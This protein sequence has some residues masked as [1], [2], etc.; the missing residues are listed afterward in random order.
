MFGFLRYKIGNGGFT[1]LEMVVVIAIIGILAAV[2]IGSYAEVREKARDTQRAADL[3]QLQIAIEAYKDTYGEYPVSG[4]GAAATVFV[5]P[6]PVNGAVP[7]LV[8]C[9]NYIEGLVPDFISELPVDLIFEYEDNR[10]IYY[11]SD[12][13]SYKLM[14]RN[15]VEADLVTGIEHRFA[16]CPVIP[17]VGQCSLGVSPTTYAV[18]SAGAEEW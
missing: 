5:G 15:V 2:G 13:V 6:G 1:L 14:F 8:S 11:R 18:Y 12:Q 3:Q 10:G 16:R 4:C 9:Q 17:A 7:N